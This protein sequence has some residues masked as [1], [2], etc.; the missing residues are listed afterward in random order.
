MVPKNPQDF[1]L[2]VSSRA[3]VHKSA[4][5]PVAAWHRILQASMLGMI[6]N[7][8]DNGKPSLMFSRDLI[9]SKIPGFSG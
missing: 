1:Y 7:G 5:L 8:E 9:T 4:C 6:G 2:E 3:G